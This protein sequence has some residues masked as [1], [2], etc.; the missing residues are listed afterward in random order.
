MPKYK[1]SRDTRISKGSAITSALFYLFVISI[2]VLSYTGHIN[3]MIEILSEERFTFTVGEI[4]ITPYII[5]KSLFAVIV[6]FWLAG[7]VTQFSRNSILRIKNIRASSRA[8]LSKT[9]TIVIYAGAFIITLN[10]IGIDL[11]ALTI[12]SGA[13]GIGLGFGLQKIASNFISGIIMLFERSIEQGDVVELES[14]IYGYIRNINA[15]YTLVETYDGKEIMIPNE[16]FIIDRVTNWTYSNSRGRL[17]LTIGVSYNADIELAQKLIFDAANKHPEVSN[18]EKVKC[19][20]IEFADSSVNFL[21]FFWIDDF[22]EGRYRIQSEVMFKIWNAFKENNIEIPFP[23]RDL[24][25]KDP[26]AL[27]AFK[28]VADKSKAKPKVKAASR[29]TKK[30]KK[31]LH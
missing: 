13:I 17:S 24:H 2:I 31:K 23:Q 4:S 29:T 12:F 20:L 10:I 6:V 1:R 8:L 5:L 9:A 16:E 30:D 14:G 19:H 18:E 15:R 28:A 7:K 11:T 26:Q 27:D 22:S 21:L 25:I 3:P